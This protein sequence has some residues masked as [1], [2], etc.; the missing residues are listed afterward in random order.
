METYGL[1]HL[2]LTFN[3]GKDCTVLLHLLNIVRKI[4]YPKYQEPLSCLY[5]RDHDTFPEQDK[6]V[7]QCQVYYNLDIVSLSQGMK[8]ALA[9]YLNRKPNLKACFLGTRRT[10]PYS[11][12]LKTFQVI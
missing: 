2:F 3:G 10:D 12:S 5:V 4:R 6:F 7:A 9:E 11:A 8:D 1:E